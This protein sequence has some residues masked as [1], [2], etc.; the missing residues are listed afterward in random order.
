[1]KTK[2]SFT[3]LLFI[4]SNLINA[5]SIEKGKILLG[6]N[7]KLDYDFIR[8]KSSNDTTHQHTG[9]IGI[10]AAYAVKKNAMLG[11][12]LNTGADFSP[13]KNGYDSDYKLFGASVFYRNYIPVVKNLSF[14][15]HSAIVGTYSKARIHNSSDYAYD[16]NSKEN[17]ISLNLTPGFSYK[18]FKNFYVDFV[19]SSFANI[20]Y[21]KSTIRDITKKSFKFSTIQNASSMQNIGIG[22]NFIL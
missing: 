10:T 5:Q 11:I 6:G 12:S 9:N 1:M 20:S 16:Y 18:V 2:I 8:N 22:F 21:S 3:L 17:S 13:N 7:F 15:V 19:V 14:F 4:F